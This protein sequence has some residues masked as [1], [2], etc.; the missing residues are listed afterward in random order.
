MF[1]YVCDTVCVLCDTVC[2]CSVYI[3]V[4]VC[5]VVVC[6]T[7]EFHIL[8]LIGTTMFAYICVHVYVCVTELELDVES[9]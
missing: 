1:V 4:C 7:L 5:A 6:S 8:E 3:C 9:L 2:V